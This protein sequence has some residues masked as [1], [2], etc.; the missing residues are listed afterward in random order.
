MFVGFCAEW[1]TA[2]GDRLKQKVLGKQEVFYGGKIFSGKSVAPPA[3]KAKDNKILERLST[4]SQSLLLKE[5]A[6]LQARKNDNQFQ[7]RLLNPTAGNGRL[8]GFFFLFTGFSTLAGLSGQALRPPS[9]QLDVP[10]RI[11]KGNRLTGRVLSGALVPRRRFQELD[12]LQRRPDGHQGQ[13]QRR[14]GSVARRRQ[15]RLGS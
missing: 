12:A 4:Q 9:G 3:S 1:N 5:Q 2:A 7:Q 15:I 8:P 14:D 11:Q 10:H 13:G 6:E